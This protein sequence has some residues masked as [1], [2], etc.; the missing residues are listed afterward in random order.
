MVRLAGIPRRVGHASDHRGWLLTDTMPYLPNGRRPHRAESFLSLLGLVWPNPQF[1]RSLRYNPG[2]DAILA[3]D[4]LLAT[5]H[6]PADKRIMGIAPGAAQPN[7]RWRAE[8]YAEVCRRWLKMDNTVVVIVGGERDTPACDAVASSER[9]D[10]LYN[11]CGGGSLPLV[12]A[13]IGH[14][15]IFVGN[16]SGLSHLA[17]AVGIPVVVVSGPGDPSEVAP[18]AKH[19]LTVKKPL[20]CSPCYRN[21]CYRKDHPLECQ[22]LVTVD[23]VWE[24][25]ETTVKRG[26]GAPP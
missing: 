9:R 8:R 12:A 14:C 26:S 17:A 25:V 22:D 24:A 19:A 23:D 2:A 5:R 4:A 10:R 3:A 6:I 20:F 11:L 18:F 7:K 16:D 21:T 1:E 13:I 15:R